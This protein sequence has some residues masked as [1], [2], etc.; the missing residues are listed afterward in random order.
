MAEQLVQERVLFWRY[1]ERDSV[2]EVYLE[3]VEGAY[4]GPL[5]VLIDVM[6]AS[7]AEEFGGALQ[8]IGRATVV[9]ERSAGICVAADTLELPNGA[10][11]VYPFR[12]TRTADGTV[13]EGHGVIPDIEV[14]LDREQLLHGIDAQL[15]AA[16]S[17]LGCKAALRAFEGER[18][19]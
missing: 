8:A 18:K 5:V 15:A 13:L 11:L 7:S 9:G 1:R 10:V 16:I 6:S 19:A 14:S 17:Q 2:G 4:S 12:Q 3:P